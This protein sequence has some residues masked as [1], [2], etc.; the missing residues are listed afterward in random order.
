MSTCSR[1]QN[2]FYFMS[3]RPSL[4]PD[5]IWRRGGCY[6]F[7]G[8]FYQGMGQLHGNLTTWGPTKW[9]AGK[10][11]R[12]MAKKE[13]TSLY[14]IQREYLTHTYCIIG[15]KLLQCRECVSVHLSLIPPHRTW[16]NRDLVRTHRMNEWQNI[17][18]WIQLMRE[19]NA[20]CEQ[21]TS[22][23][24]ATPSLTPS[25]ISMTFLRH[26]WLP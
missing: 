21:S 23:H 16:H 11:F 18:S 9:E 22:W 26:S 6:S 2:V 10:T 3:F 12:S 17:I 25:E 19:Q 20:S 14:I 1:G 4:F 15:C 24:P 5:E 7:S 8:S 13:S